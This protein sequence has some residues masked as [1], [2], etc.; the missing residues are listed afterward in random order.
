[1]SAEPVTREAFA[2]LVSDL[3]GELAEADE[4][5][6]AALFRVPRRTVP[7][8]WRGQAWVREY[9]GVTEVMDLTNLA[10]NSVRLFDSQARKA[11]ATKDLTFTYNYGGPP[12]L[13]RLMPPSDKEKDGAEDDRKRHRRWMIGELALWVAARED[14]QATSTSV[15]R[16]ETSRAELIEQ[17]QAI[18]ERDGSVTAD[19]ITRELDLKPGGRLAAQL[20]HDSGLESASPNA[21]SATPGQ[22]M[23]AA[24]AVM[25]TCGIRADIPDVAAVLGKAGV[26]AAPKRV[27]RAL[28]AARLEVIR[29][30]LNPTV[31]DQGG[32]LESLRSDGLVT[33]AQVA[34]AF[35]IS[36]GGVTKAWER[37][38][39]K[40]AKWEPYRGGLRRL[41]D[42][43]RLWVR[44]D[45]RRG[46][47]D[48][49]S[50]L[51]AKINLD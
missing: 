18:Y 6:R 7:E 29:A 39:V 49:D 11:R 14:R 3:R 16:G 40:V 22:L 48:V 2:A 15:G 23:D 44:E 10:R 19:G 41:Y 32:E 51:A 42:P 50:P 5:R 1:M 35:G 27:R 9:V 21:H 8:A 30:A 24:R 25:K 17:V 20:I 36:D 12:Q 45:G 28:G 34:R 26:R 31:D 37:H 46:P 4:K 13:R 38:E 43:A 47:V 33:G